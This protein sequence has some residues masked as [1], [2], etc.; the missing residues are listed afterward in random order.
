MYPRNDI[1]VA[2]FSE[3]S[4]FA[5]YNTFYL[6]PS[7]AVAIDVDFQLIYVSPLYIRQSYLGSKC[8]L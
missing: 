3:R 8:L 1:I 7:S 6:R 4:G 2:I 5:E